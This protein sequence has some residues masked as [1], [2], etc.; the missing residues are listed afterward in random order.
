[1]MTLSV[2]GQTLSEVRVLFEQFH[3]MILGTLDPT[4]KATQLGDLAIFM[5]VREFPSRTKCASL[6][7]HALICAIDNKNEVSTE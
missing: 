6:G 1:M 3:A 4:Q 5:G 7:W 2:Q